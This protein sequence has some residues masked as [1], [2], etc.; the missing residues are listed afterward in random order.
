M[1]R[2]AVPHPS[3]PHSS[4]GLGAWLGA[5]DRTQ[6]EAL[7]R[8]RPDAALAPVPTTVGELA[9]KLHRTHS[10]AGAMAQLS[11]PALQVAEAVLALGGSAARAQLLD[12]FG[13]AEDGLAGRVDQALDELLGLALVWPV[14][15]QVRLAGGW[16]ELI[17][18]PLS[19]GAP[20]RTLFGQLTVA[21]LARIGSSLGI[22]GLN[23]KD[24]WVTAVAAAVADP[25]TVA[26]RLEQAGPLAD[27]VEAVAWQGP[28]VSG[29]RFPGDY[30]RSDPDDIGTQL[31]V[32]GWVVPSG[33]GV[34]EM[35]REV[36]LAVRGP[37]YH[38]PFDAAPPRPAAAVVDTAQL[39]AAGPA[40]AGSSVDAVRRLVT[41]VQATPLPQV[42]VGGVGVREVRRMAKTLG[43]DEAAARLWLETAAAAGLLAAAGDEVLATEQSDGWL[44]ADPGDALAGLLQAWLGLWLVPGHRVDDA[45]KPAPALALAYSGAEYA[46]LRMFVLEMLADLPPGQGLVDPD[47][48][49]ALLAFTRPALY[50]D[51]EWALQ[52]HA[53][54]VEAQRWG[55]VSA[56]ALTPLGRDVLAAALADEPAVALAVASTGVLP[57]PTRTAT[58]LPDLTAIVAGGAAAALARLLDSAADAESR[59]TASTWRFTPATVRRAL[60]AGRTADDLLAALAAV[61]DNPLPQPLQYLVRDVARRH[62]QLRVLTVASCITVADVALAAEVAAHRALA[63][64]KLRRLSDTVL[65]GS[66]PAAE[67]IAA[68]RKA[69][70]APIRQDAAG[71]TVIERPPQRRATREAG[72]RRRN[73]PRVD[74][75]ALAARLA[76]VEY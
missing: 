42:K 31:V 49:A 44:A 36:A 24:D 46:Q 12:L 59:D 50:G 67:V 38:A 40:A 37:D 32:A 69:G 63:P 11:L 54:L 65:A 17:T 53:T 9:A 16:R 21:Q 10:I 19:L 33:W 56:G 14:G 41:L 43:A 72:P 30:E 39:Q 35:P 55:L 28:Q 52:V 26:A 15:A 23:R 51:A 34:G 66:K 62:G 3:G 75:G 47:Q 13:I 2:S 5:L 61:A 7:L 4:S 68:L 60:D 58:F 74:V 57:A 18:H 22:G 8:A 76:G 6:L 29:V 45:G 27:A 48:L 25:H 73:Q 71:Q 20:A 1:T 64:L 70:Y